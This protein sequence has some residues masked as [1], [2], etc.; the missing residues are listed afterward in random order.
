[1]EDNPFSNHTNNLTLCQP[2]LRS[3]PILKY[4]SYHDI[5]I[6]G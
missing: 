6:R 2:Y 1:M 4:G 3:H 5:Y